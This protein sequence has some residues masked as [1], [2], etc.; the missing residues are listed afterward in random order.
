[1]FL[2]RRFSANEQDLAEKFIGASMEN[3]SLINIK[4]VIDCK[5]IRFNVA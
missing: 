2:C 1:M 5:T 3:W 4:L